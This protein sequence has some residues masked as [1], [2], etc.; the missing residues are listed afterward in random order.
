MQENTSVLTKSE[1]SDAVIQPYRFVKLTS[2]GVD[3][4]TA[5]TDKIY[6]A[7]RGNVANDAGDTVAIVVLGT[8]I[9]EASAA[10]SKGD[11]VTATTGGKAVATT[12]AGNVVRGI[13][14]EDAAE[15]GD[16]IEVMLVYFQ[17]STT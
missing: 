2:T 6:G 8:V 14:L 11:Y 9:V 10:I 3:V 15:D 16:L 13:A 17:V 7:Y 12:T 4:A 1:L 5:G